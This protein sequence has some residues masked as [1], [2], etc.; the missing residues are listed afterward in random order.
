MDY[1]KLSYDVDIVF[2]IDVKG[3]TTPVLTTIKQN[4]LNLY[5]DLKRAMENMD[6]P[7]LIDQMVL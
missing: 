7:K 4:A 6:T 3:S 5:G 2:C 1:Y